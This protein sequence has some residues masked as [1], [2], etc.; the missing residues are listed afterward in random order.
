V[1]DWLDRSGWDH[2]PPA[3]ALPPEV[4]VA[5]RERY[6]QAAAHLMGEAEARRLGLAPA[7]RA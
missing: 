2:E 3:P 7:G 1:R 5:T 6:V 4:V